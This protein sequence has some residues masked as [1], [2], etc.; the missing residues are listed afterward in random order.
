MVPASTLMYGSILI[1]V[2]LKPLDFKI[3][4]IEEVATPFA[5]A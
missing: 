4:P 5:D 1:A 3:R 2:T